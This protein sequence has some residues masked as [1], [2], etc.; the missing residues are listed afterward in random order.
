MCTWFEGEHIDIQHTLHF[1]IF[2]E[3][4]N[5]DAGKKKKVKKKVKKKG[6]KKE[7]ME[8]I[9]MNNYSYGD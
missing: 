6:K 7:K 5:A 1:V 9:I 2:I 4:N 8:L 3:Q